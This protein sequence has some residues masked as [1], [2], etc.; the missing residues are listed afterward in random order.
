MTFNDFC[1]KVR[2]N[3]PSIMPEVGEPFAIEHLGEKQYVDL[4][5]ALLENKSVTY[6]RLETSTYMKDSAEAMAKYIRSSKHLQRILWPTPTRRTNRSEDEKSKQHEEMLCCFLP[7][8]QESMSLKELNIYFPLISE[9]SNL[10]F[11]KMLTHTQSLRSLKIICRAGPL[12]DIFVAAALS[13]LKRNTTLRELT[14]NAW[15]GASTTILP[16]LNSLHDHPN[17]RRLCLCGYVTDLTGLE[18]VLLSDNSKITELEI[19]IGVST[20]GPRMIGLTPVLQALGRHPSPTLT[21]LILERLHRIGLDDVRLLQTALRNTPTLQIL[22]LT[23]GTLVSAGLAELAPALYR[24]TSI[25]VLDVSGNNLSDMESAEILRDV[26]RRNTTMTTLNLSGNKFG[27]T[28]GAVECIAD[29]LG[30]NST[31][32]E[33]DLSSC[34][35][36]DVG[37]STLAQTLGSRNTML[38]KL[39]LSDNSVRSAGVGVLLET[40]EQNDHH[41]TNLDL[42]LNPIGYEG[43]SLLARSL[44]NNALSNLTNLSLCNCDIGDDGQIT[45]ISALEQNTSLLQL[46]LRISNGLSER[47]FLALAESLPEIKILQRLDLSWCEGL[48]SAMPLLLAGLRRNTSLFRCHVGDSAPRRSPPTTE[49]TAKCAGGWMQEMACLGYRNRFRPLIRA[50]EERHPPRGLWPHALARVAPLPDAIFE[51]L[52]SKPNL[53][54]SEDTEATQDTG[55]AKKRKQGDE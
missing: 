12:G 6:L 26:L 50:P 25:K 54:P 41:T 14:L 23:E 1:V 3:D 42:Q 45:L 10:A 24:N 27:E 43:A 34:E 33:I 19:K 36:E 11:E 55:V 18:T 52:R 5:D 37:L 31:L 7:A 48:A 17:L 51:L 9:P 4:A 47:V 53:A 46:D 40:M 28:T 15:R 22:V 44:G 16:I 8:I 29:G 32:L 38:Q 20:G 13:G 30:S 35:L 21:K 39:T 2:N 49:E